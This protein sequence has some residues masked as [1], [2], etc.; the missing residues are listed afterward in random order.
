MSLE[1]SNLILETEAEYEA[2]LAAKEH[3]IHQQEEQIELLGQLEEGHRL[4]QLAVSR[5]L[6]EHR[7]LHQFIAKG[8]W[9]FFWWLCLK[10]IFPFSV[11][12]Y[13]RHE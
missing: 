1:V 3:I 5:E 13:G 2:L 10:D 12:W 9:G 11:W 8:P 6:A 7:E 4:H